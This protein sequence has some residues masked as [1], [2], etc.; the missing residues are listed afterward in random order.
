MMRIGLCGGMGSGKS[1]VAA[2]LRERGAHLIDADAIARDIVQ[3]GSAALLEIGARF[4]P[5]VLL[6]DGS[7][8]RA[9]LARIAFSDAQ[10]LQDLEAITHPRIWAATNE[11]FA[12]LPADAIAVHD[13]PLLV[14]KRMSPEY[15]LVIAVLADP[16]RRIRRLVDQRGLDLADVLR[17]ITVQASDAQRRAAAD[18]LIDNNTTPRELASQVGQ[19]WHERIVPFAANLAAGLPASPT[20][21][22]ADAVILAQQAARI[23]ARIRRAESGGDHLDAVP[24][25]MTLLQ[26]RTQILH[27]AIPAGQHGEDPQRDEV[28]RRLT[29]AGFPPIAAEANHRGNADPAWPADIELTSASS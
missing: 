15:H 11:Q 19:L 27:V 20:R 12:A 14:E 26:R 23:A 13:M 10:A 24:V 2:L 28:S 21:I 18:V 22:S 25:R 4:G 16:E 6:P 17:R 9:A 1:T 5:R 29:Q 7:S 3:P 8:D